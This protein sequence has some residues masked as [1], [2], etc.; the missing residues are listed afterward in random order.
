MGMPK[1]VSVFC[2]QDCFKAAWAIHKSLHKP[3]INSYMYVLD[4]GRLRGTDLPVFEWTG[5][6]RPFR[7]VCAPEMLT[8]DKAARYVMYFANCSLL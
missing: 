4:H 6:L 7:Y 2:S 1:H 3:S 8:A 5:P